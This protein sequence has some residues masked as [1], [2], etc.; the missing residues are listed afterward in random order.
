MALLSVLVVFLTLFAASEAFLS[1]ATLE[2][3]VDRESAIKTLDHAIITKI[4]LLRCMVEFF[5]DNPQYIDEKMTTK[6]EDLQGIVITADNPSD[7]QDLFRVVMPRMRLQNA[8]AEIQSS[9]A[10]INSAPLKNVAAAHFS[11]EQFKEGSKRLL[12]LKSQIITSLLKSVKFEH[13]R[14]LS[15]QYLHTLQD[16]YSHSNWLE[17]GNRLRKFDPLTNPANSILSEFIAKPNEETCISCPLATELNDNCDNNLI[18][19]KITSG[20]YGGQDI[21][22]PM[23]VSKCSHGGKLDSSRYQGARGGINKESTSRIWSP[24]Y[25]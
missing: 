2:L 21:S 25:K 8:M 5:K 3:Q 1:S 7:I 17:L 10:E 11:G 6:F 14:R 15:G 4:G 22:K 16:F 19:Q 9:N 23:N 18:I 13:A 20:Y 24:H 12:E